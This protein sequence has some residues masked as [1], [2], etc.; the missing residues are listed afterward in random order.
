MNEDSEQQPMQYRK[1]RVRLPEKVVQV[2]DWLVEHIQEHNEGQITRS[3]ILSYGVALVFVDLQRRIQREAAKEQPFSLEDE[4]EIVTQQIQK[5]M[6]RDRQVAE[7]VEQATRQT[8]L[9]L[10]QQILEGLEVN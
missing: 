4:I 9:P 5:N 2:L 3:L 10:W 1:I 8:D 6:Q 7:A